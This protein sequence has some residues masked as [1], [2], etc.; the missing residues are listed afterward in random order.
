MPA[1]LITMAGPAGVGKSTLAQRLGAEFERAGTPV[2]VFGE[3]EIFTRREFK[4]VGD[5]FRSQ[6][7]ATAREFEAAYRTWLGDLAVETVAIM[8]WNPAGMT[9]D[10]PWATE[11]RALYGA[12]L[13]A[14]RTLADGRVLLLQLKAPPETA[15]QRARRERGADWVARADEVARS[16]G[17]H[18][19]EQQARIIASAEAHLE[20][21][22]AE[23]GVA[24]AAGWPVRRIDAGGSVHDV[25]G[26][27]MT[28]IDEARASQGGP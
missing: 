20:Q 11:D 4:R 17:H 2:D 26:Q 25:L 21:T 1:L 5:G 28:V 18:Q 16:R 9:G 3:E 6:D 7:Y 24:A 12:H 15:V 10:L 19:A 14:V 23:L 8:D 13:A 22:A 27:A